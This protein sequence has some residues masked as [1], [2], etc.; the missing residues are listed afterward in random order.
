MAQ[1]STSTV[2][3]RTLI[4]LYLA[5]GQAQSISS[6][7]RHDGHD[8]SFHLMYYLTV[9]GAEPVVTDQKAQVYVFPNRL[10]L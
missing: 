8:V 10:W 7:T 4:Q 1:H 2:S 3:T 5:V 9:W 6:N